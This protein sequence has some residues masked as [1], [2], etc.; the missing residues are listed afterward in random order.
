MLQVGYLADD[1]QWEE[2]ISFV[3]RMDKGNA[4]CFD[5]SVFR[6]AAAAKLGHPDAGER[7]QAVIAGNPFA[8]EVLANAVLVPNWGRGFGVSLGSWQEGAEVL[9]QH[10]KV[11][12]DT[13]LR[14]IW[15][16][17]R[18]SMLRAQLE[19]VKEVRRAQAHFKDPARS[20]DYIER[21][22]TPF[23]GGFVPILEAEW[24]SLW[25]ELAPSGKRKR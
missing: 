9:Q 2:L 3:D 15:D 24:S 12:Q 23:Y 21:L 18:P 10:A 8:A 13:Q 7:F 6:A 14:G 22:R 4:A 5:I 20:R 11:W 19:R 1:Q 17:L 16:D 25:P